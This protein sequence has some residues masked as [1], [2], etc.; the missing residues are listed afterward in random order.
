MSSLD[1]RRSAR[2]GHGVRVE[3]LE[4]RELLS[5][6]FNFH[7]ASSNQGRSTFNIS[8]LAALAAG[9]S[10]AGTGGSANPQPTQRELA[11]EHFVAKLTGTYGTGQGRYTNQAFQVAILAT[12]GSNQS[13]HLNLQMVFF[14]PKD[15]TQPV[16]GFASL[17]PKNVSS[18]GNEIG[19]DLTANAQQPGFHGFPTQ[20][21]WTLNGPGA[22]NTSS[23]GSYS[24]ATGQGTLDI[25]Y[26]PSGKGPLRGLGTGQIALDFQGLINSIGVNNVLAA[27]GNRPTH[28]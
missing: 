17:T 13:F 24:G 26:F 19:L 6:A 2:Q 20:F 21:T 22:I 23:G 1:R 7:A 10:G 27:P 9:T 11:R 16:T 8:A 15:T 5:T 14:F 3:L 12:G 4:G 25:R 28:P 18:S